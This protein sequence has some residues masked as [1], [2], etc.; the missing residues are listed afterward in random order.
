LFDSRRTGNS[1]SSSLSSANAGDSGTPYTVHGR[2]LD[3]VVRELGLQRIDVLKADV[4]GAE[5][6]VLS[7]ARDVLTR[8][9]PTLILEV[10]PGQLENMGTSVQAL[11][12]LLA[13][14]GYR[15]SRWVDYKNKEYL[16]GQ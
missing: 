15:R 4:E 11:E 14:V 1:G 12:G 6:L 9:R 8:F 10:V 16:F 13:S 5:V 7:G 3:D 2:R